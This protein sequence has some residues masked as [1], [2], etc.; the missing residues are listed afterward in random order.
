[1]A[2]KHFILQNH[3][4]LLPKNAMKYFISLEIEHASDSNN[5]TSQKM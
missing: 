2:N 4:L 5:L 3:I 1:V